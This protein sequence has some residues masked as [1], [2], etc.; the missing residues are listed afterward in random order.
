MQKWK[1]VPQSTHYDSSD[2]TS[3]YVRALLTFWKE[4]NIQIDK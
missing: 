4:T 3:D 2:S 1:T